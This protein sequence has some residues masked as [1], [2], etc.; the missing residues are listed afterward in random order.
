MLRITKKLSDYFLKN[1]LREPKL[2]QQLRVATAKLPNAEMQISAEQGQFMALLVKLI[3]ARKTLDIGVFTGYSSLAVALALPDNG[4]VIACDID[5][6]TT[7]IAQRYWQKARVAHKIDLILAPA[8]ETLAKFI[9]SGKKNR[10]DF[11]FIDADKVNYPTYYEQCLQLMRKG[12]LIA[13]D[14]MFRDGKIVD[15]KLHDA[16]TLATRK[17][18]NMIHKDKRVEASLV[19]IRDGVML[20]RKI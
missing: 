17:L 5:P 20:V 2:L 16:A 15:F 3:N 19:P 14:N 4:K 8:T 11:A 7:K 9:S 13:I 10:F 1:T 12:G 18:I 6:V